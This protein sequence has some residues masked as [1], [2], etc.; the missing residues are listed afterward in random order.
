MADSSTFKIGIV[1]FDARARAI[2]AF[3]RAGDVV[4]ATVRGRR[5]A[6]AGAPQRAR[7]AASSARPPGRTRR[8]L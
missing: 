8:G 6:A 5:V 4:A 1:K 7:A 3:S 2:D